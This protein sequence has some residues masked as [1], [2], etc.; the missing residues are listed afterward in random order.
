M[1]EEMGEEVEEEE[2]G[3]VGSDDNSCLRDI[4]P[5]ALPLTTCQLHSL[6]R[7]DN[8]KEHLL[9]TRRPGHIILC[10]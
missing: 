8:A 9:L 5:P 2:M 1:E 3:G 7:R 4:S 6:Q 10:K